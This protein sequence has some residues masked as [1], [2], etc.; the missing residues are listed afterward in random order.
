M[1][2]RKDFCCFPGE[3]RN[4]QTRSVYLMHHRVGAVSDR[5]LGGTLLDGWVP[6]VCVWVCVGGACRFLLCLQLR[7]LSLRRAVKSVPARIP[8]EA[9]QRRDTSESVEISTW[10]RKVCV[11]GWWMSVDM[12]C[13]TAC[14]EREGDK[15]T[16]KRE[17]TASS[18]VY[19]PHH[20]RRRAAG[21]GAWRW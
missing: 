6:R 20:R 21:P 7:S 17:N 4:T 18:L 11:C 2:V 19:M 1:L 14:G 5:K 16:A 10:S 8:T 9:T 3:E 12:S 15:G 13:F